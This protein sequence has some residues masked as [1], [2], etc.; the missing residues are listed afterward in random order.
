[1][2]TSALLAM[3]AIACSA[4]AD[5]DDGPRIEFLVPGTQMPLPVGADVE[6]SLRPQGVYGAHVDMRVF[7]IEAIAA[8]SIALVE[9][10]RVLARQ[11]FLPID[12][13]AHLPDGSF[14]LAELPVVFMEGIE[15]SEV[16]GDAAVLR[17]EMETTPPV[18]GECDVVLASVE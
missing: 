16:D 18:E 8:F 9:G 6:V 5:P 4:E 15:P 1:M 12:P 7:G 11:P 3:L 2:R 13:T 14:V 10:D 17:A